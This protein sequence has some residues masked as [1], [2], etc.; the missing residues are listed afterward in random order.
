LY[1][2]G[3]NWAKGRWVSIDLHVHSVYSGGT[4]TPLEILN[5]AGSAL[6][7]AVAIS[8]HNEVRGAI[9]GQIIAQANPG[10]PLVLASQEVSAGDHFHFLLAGSTR[11]QADVG[12]GKLAEILELHKRS[13][14][15]VLLA[16]PWTVWRKGWTQGCLREL[17]GAGLVDGVE[18][19][20]ASLLELSNNERSILRNIWDEWVLPHNLAV[21]GGS[22]FHYRDKGRRIGAGRTYLKVFQPGEAGILEALAARRSIA[23]LFGC[24]TDALPGLRYGALILWGNEPWRDELYGLIGTLRARL[25][26]LCRIHPNGR[27]FLIRLLDAGHFQP[28]EDLLF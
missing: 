9:E 14:G 15:V 6:L 5:E 20:N 11:P 7:D 19:A 17:V 21:V 22:D 10:L 12:R 24:G 23:G 13:G 26:C 1:Y 28:V 16:H 4:L 3:I 2:K 25:Q 8:D 27:N 18:L